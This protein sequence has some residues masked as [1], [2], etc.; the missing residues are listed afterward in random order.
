MRGWVAQHGRRNCSTNHRGL[1]G[2]VP[3]RSRLTAR[4]PRACVYLNGPCYFSLNHCFSNK[5]TTTRP[6]RRPLGGEQQ[7]LDLLV[8]VAVAVHRVAAV[9]AP[10]VT[11]LRPNPA[12]AEVSEGLQPRPRWRPHEHVR[13]A[14][15]L[16]RAERLLCGNQGGVGR[17]ARTHL[18]I[19]RLAEAGRGWPRLAEAKGWPRLA[20]ARGRPEFA[21]APARACCR[22][23]GP[24]PLGGWMSH[25]EAPPAAPAR[26][27]ASAAQ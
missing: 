1:A 15:R 11:L 6:H 4:V 10:P 7:T 12:R 20:E 5:S 26:A 9:D 17:P 24:K 25:E 13:T 14:Q 18:P 19:S 27:G 16:A 22:A 3:C 23:N 8:R 21:L 2:V